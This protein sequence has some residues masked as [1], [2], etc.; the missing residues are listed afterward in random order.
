MV[1]KIPYDKEFLDLNIAD[2]KVR[3]VLRASTDDFAPEKI[4]PE[5]VQDALQNPIDSAP[6]RELAVGK[7]NVVVITSDHTRAVPSKITLPLLL[8]EIRAGNPDAKITI[9]IATGAHRAMTEAE[10]RAKFGDEIVDHEKIVNNDAFGNDFN[11]IRK[12]P[13]GAD[14]W[15]NNVAMNCDLLVA[16]GFVEPH[17]FAGFS[18]GRKSILPGVCNITTIK[19]NHS[20]MALNSHYATAGVTTNN[21]VHHDMV[22][23]AKIAKLQFILNVALNSKKQV[24]AAFAGDMETAHNKA[25][26]FV[27]SISA[28][29]AV[30]SDIVITSNGGY[31]LDQNLY[32]GPKAVATAAKCC[33][34][35]GVIIMS[36]ACSDGFGGE[37]FKKLMKM[38]NPAEIEEYLSKIEPEYTLPQQWCV[39]KFVEVLKDRKLILISALPDDDVV[40]ANMIPA[41]SMDEALAKA[42]EIVGDDA[43]ATIIPDGVAVFCK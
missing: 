27:S 39:Q 25:V 43:M 37:S 14:F 12:L 28:R 7:N 22:T 19:Q 34:K 24:I 31:P 3:A 38:G 8:A 21:P 18:G 2:E 29:E 13:S 16:E 42:Y 4:E 17:F 9:L 33:R 20:Y 35:N 6:L 15:L 40:K 30:E 10:Q 26:E 32:Q 23:A 11:F 36:C 41:H 5:L 1:L